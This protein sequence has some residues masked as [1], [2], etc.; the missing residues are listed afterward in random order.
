M[1]YLFIGFMYSG[2]IPLL[3]PILTG[4]LIL[5]FYCKKIIVTKYSVKIPA[6]E[7]LS[8]STLTFIPI[9][10]LVHGLF[11]V[12]SH[13][14]NGIFLTN[15]PLVRSSMTV[16]SSSLDRIFN[17]IIIL[18]EPALILLIMLL[19]LTIFSFIGFLIDCCKDELEMP[20][21]WA[22]V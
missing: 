16:F 14:T 21:Q 13:T 4:G 5:S 12:W 2:L 15:S 18:G 17:D 6:D 1:L 8:E 9:I 7:T 3:I 10:I 19:D 20:V 22:A 11:S